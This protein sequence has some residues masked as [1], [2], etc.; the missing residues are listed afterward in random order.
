MSKK[1]VN[2]LEMLVNSL[3]SGDASN[4]ELSI[5]ALAERIANNLHG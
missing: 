2:E 5:T 3:K 1:L 4:Q